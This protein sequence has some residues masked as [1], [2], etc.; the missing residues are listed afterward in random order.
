MSSLRSL[1]WRKSRG[2]WEIA[3]DW[4]SWVAA[5][6]VAYFFLKY[7]YGD[8]RKVDRAIIGTHDAAAFELLQAETNS[9]VKER[10]RQAAGQRVEKTSMIHRAIRE[11]RG[12]L[13][14]QY[15]YM[16]GV[17]NRITPQ[18]IVSTVET[19]E[20]REL[21]QWMVEHGNSDD[22]KRDLDLTHEQLRERYKA[23]YDP[24]A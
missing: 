13:D 16:T 23:H 21:R 20:A 17:Q 5:G 1:R 10:D 12:E 19:A 6:T 4:S 3:Q 2:M 7:T 22:F 11:Q 24:K 8:T 9:T 18:G 14:P 15:D